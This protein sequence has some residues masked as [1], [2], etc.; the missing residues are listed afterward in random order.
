MATTDKKKKLSKRWRIAMWG[1]GGLVGALAL[2]VGIL[3]KEAH[4]VINNPCP[5]DVEAG[6]YNDLAALPSQS[7]ENF[8]ANAYGYRQY[9]LIGETNHSDTAINNFVHSE[10]NIRSMSQAGIENIFLERGA[11]RAFFI[12]QLYS[13]EI[14]PHEFAVGWGF[15]RWLSDSDALQ[16]NLRL[17][18]SLLIYREQ[19]IQPYAVDD[20]NSTSSREDR[21]AS[22]KED[23]KLVEY[24]HT[25]CPDTPVL[26]GRVSNA[27]SFSQLFGYEEMPSDEE[28]E[29]IMNR[30]NERDDDSNR[31]EAIQSIS[32]NAK[33]VI[34]YGAAHFDNAP[35]SMHSLLGSSSLLISV[36]SSRELYAD[37]WDYYQDALIGRTT[38]PDFV[39]I[40]DEGKVYQTGSVSF[41]DLENAVR[42]RQ[43]KTVAL[44]R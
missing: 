19:G 25:S 42:T 1:G 11:T 16:A 22:Y 9:T 21:S 39:H 20:S 34:F 38:R 37:T 43:P 41:Q 5:I 31:I 28:F 17:A 24:F 4:D 12:G 44:T 26:H 35:Q 32:Q 6:L 15:N 36:Y 10:Q 30:S 23:R 7:P 14:T 33:S 27:F 13:E 29:G 8:Y 18:D 2:G 40:I 3:T